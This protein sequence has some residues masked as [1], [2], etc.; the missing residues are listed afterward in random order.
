VPVFAYRAR[1]ASGR[2]E[3]GLVDA[4]SVRSA[5]QQ[6]RG[7]GVFPTDLR[8]G[9]AD[10][11]AGER[12]DARER[13][14]ALRQLAAL[15][16]AGVP[17]AEALEGVREDA[18]SP[19]L[20]RAVTVVRARLREG[21]SLA[22]ALAACPRAFSPL[23]RELVRAGEAAG[24][25]AAVLERLARDEAAAVE[26]RARLR[27]A[28]VYPG[29]MLAT[30][31]LVLTFLLV[32]VVPQVTRLLADTGTPLPLATRALVVTAAALRATWWLWAA[33]VVLGALG[34][35]RWYATPA[36]RH[37]IDAFLLRAPLV[38]RLVATR[39]SAR[40]TRVLAT[41]LG[42]G[43]SLDHALRL[44]ARTGGNVEIAAAVDRVRE[45]VLRGG[46]LAPA[47]RAHDLLGAGLCRLVATGERTGRLADAFEQAADRQDADVER[48][49]GAVTALVE[50]MLVV[51]MGGAVLV[52]VLA[53]LVPI[54]TLD[55][56]GG[57]R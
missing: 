25:L 22:D 55:P 50:P 36:G 5:W 38:G 19:A 42:H 14:A 2:A 6:L 53:I 29:V 3:H 44:A 12:V 51:V 32:W 33:G 4:E 31:S 9:D 43:V 40:V 11:A 49:L 46:A 45:E 7:R 16:G 15:V 52:L 37:T 21:L 56:L 1:T 18:A 39:A 54:L 57:A 35:E 24:A 47:L 23:H 34:L 13:A 41:M 10:A 27:A 20:R 26:R 30:T 17:I 8:A 28:L 48:A